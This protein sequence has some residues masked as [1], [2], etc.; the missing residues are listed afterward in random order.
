MYWAQAATQDEGGKMSKSCPQRAEPKN[1]E[2][3]RERRT[4]READGAVL[5][6]KG[7]YGQG[8]QRRSPAKSEKE[9]KKY[10]TKKDVKCSQKH[11]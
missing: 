9:R 5:S 11:V 3:A 2:S 8:H 4:G 10:R 7:H 6:H 1:A